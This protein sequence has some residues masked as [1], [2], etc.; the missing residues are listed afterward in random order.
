MKGNILHEFKEGK[1]DVVDNDW[2]AQKIML[3]LGVW[4]YFAKAVAPNI[5]LTIGVV[6]NHPTHWC[7]CSR[8]RNNPNR[9]KNGF[10]ILAFPKETMEAATVHGI[11]KQQRE[12]TPLTDIDIVD[13]KP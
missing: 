10:Q 8:R 3:Q 4:D 5:T 13:P 9:Y 2:V 7:I 11:M 12:G 1:T 6:E